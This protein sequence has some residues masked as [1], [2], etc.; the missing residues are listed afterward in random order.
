MMALA[1]ASRRE[2][3]YWVTA[4]KSTIFLAVVGLDRE[5]VGIEGG[6]VEQGAVEG[7]G[8]VFVVL[9]LPEGGEEVRGLEAGGVGSELHEE[10]L[11]VVCRHGTQGVLPILR[12]GDLGGRCV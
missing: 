11:V 1:N 5:D 4:S 10:H 2:E 6:D 8:E 12:L 9:L 7:G 3:T